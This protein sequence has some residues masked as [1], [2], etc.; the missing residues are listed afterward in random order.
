MTD[1][2]EQGIKWW[3]R[4]DFVPLAVALIGGG[5]EINRGEAGLSEWG[6]ALATRFFHWKIYRRTMNKIFANFSNGI[7][8]VKL[9][10]LA[11]RLF[12]C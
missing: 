7:N 1:E 9:N 3:V 6:R 11:I 8:V 10:S 2:K 12:F 5:Q 4:Y